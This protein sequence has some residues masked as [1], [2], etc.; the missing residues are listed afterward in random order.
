MNGLRIL[1]AFMP[2][3]NPPGAA[4]PTYQARSRLRSRAID[5][6]CN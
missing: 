1:S 5:W 2:R 6:L 4:A 3:S